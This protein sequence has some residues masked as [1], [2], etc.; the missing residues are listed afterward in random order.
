MWQR[1]SITAA[2]TY[3]VRQC[4]DLL[5]RNSRKKKLQSGKKMFCYTII[6][7]ITWYG[8]SEEELK[9]KAMRHVYRISENKYALDML[10]NHTGNNQLGMR[11]DIIISNRQSHSNDNR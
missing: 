2:T 10:C 11:Y 5:H 3:M 8:C 4:E 6:C 7:I 1:V 9:K